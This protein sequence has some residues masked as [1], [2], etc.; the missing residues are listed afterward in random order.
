MA[1][2]YQ[3][4]SEFAKNIEKHWQSVVWKPIVNIDKISDKPGIYKL[5]LVDPC[6]LPEGDDKIFK[7]CGKDDAKIT[8]TLMKTN[9]LSVGKTKHLKTRL[10]QH[11]GNCIRNN[12]L[13]RR[14]ESIGITVAEKKIPEKCLLYYCEIEEWWQR[15]LLEAYG[16]AISGALF[17]LEFEH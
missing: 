14:L 4:I 5:I 16:K 10:K 2:Q 15:D 17:D 13:K 9:I 12:R 11:F 6:N 3:I 8:G 1:T 7:V